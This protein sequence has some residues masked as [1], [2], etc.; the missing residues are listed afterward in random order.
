MPLRDFRCEECKACFE[1]LVKGDDYSWVTCPACSSGNVVKLLSTFVGRSGDSCRC[2]K[3]P[4]GCA[5]GCSG[6]SGGSCGS[7]G[8]H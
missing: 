5:G 3:S 8:C 7:C 1:E 4:S 2:S 6:C